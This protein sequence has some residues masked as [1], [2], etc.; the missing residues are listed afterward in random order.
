MT[1]LNSNKRSYRICLYFLPIY[2]VTREHISQ[3]CILACDWL[4][5][6]CFASATIL[7]NR[8]LVSAENAAESFFMYN[9][10][11][12]LCFPAMTVDNHFFTFQTCLSGIL[13]SKRVY[14][15]YYITNVSIRY[16]TLQTCLSGI[17]HSKRVY[18]VYLCVTF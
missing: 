18:Q 5:A 3:M 14:Q 7:I 15:V 9:D 13:H 10:Y 1:I 11:T 12:T 6:L 16:I 4:I 17:L 8:H 2:E